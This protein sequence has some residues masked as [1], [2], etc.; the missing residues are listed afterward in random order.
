MEL[1]EIKSFLDEKVIKFNQPSFIDNDPISIPHLYQRKEDI[2]IS[3]FLTATIAWGRRDLILKS[4]HRLMELLEH[5]P[6]EFITEANQREW[7]RFETFYYRTFSSV[8]CLYFIKALHEIYTQNKGLEGVF[9]DQYQ[10]GNIKP[11]LVHFRDIFLS[12]DPLR[13]THKHVANILNGASAKRINMYLRWMVRN[14]MNGV[15]FGIWKKIKTADLLLPLDLHTGNIS[16]KLG[17]LKRKQNDIKAVDEVMT[18]L[19]QFDS[20]D[21]VKYDFALFGL[22]VEEKF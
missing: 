1:S 11:V 17:I 15:D 13:R 7:S 2:E 20:N 19:R 10:S 21:P 6:F 16:R 18:I 8:D 4:A 22:G 5:S 12:F 9:S 3:G 14:D